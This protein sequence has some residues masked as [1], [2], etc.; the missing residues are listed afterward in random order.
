MSFNWKWII[1][2]SSLIIQFIA[3]GIVSSFGVLLL[4]II[5]VFHTNAEVASWIGSIQIFVVHFTGII[6][7]PLLKIFGARNVVIAGSILCAGGCLASAFAPNV[8]V[9][10]FTYGTLTGI[11]SGFMNVTTIVVIQFWFAESQRALATGIVTSGVGLGTAVFNPLLEYLTKTVHFHWTQR[12]MC[13]IFI[14]GVPCGMLF[15]PFHDEQD[16]FNVQQHTTNEE[17][18]ESKANINTINEKGIVKKCDRLTTEV[19]D[20]SLFERPAFILYCFASGMHAFGLYVPTTYIPLLVK[21]IGIPPKYSTYLLSIFGISNISS[22]FICGCFGNIGG[23]TRFYLMLT[24]YIG[25]GFLNVLISLHNS[26]P[27]LVIYSVCFSALTGCI[28]TLYAVVLV[29]LFGIENVEKSVGLCLFLTS[30]FY[31]L[32]VPMS[33]FIIDR[34]GSEVLPFTI[35]G[36]ISLLGAF[37]FM[38]IKCFHK[39]NDY[40]QFRD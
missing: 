27:V 12:V 30:F 40:E 7:G 19:A 13:L 22:R 38:L 32:G 6:G 14:I 29:D 9:L 35:I 37:T 11:G 17:E 34:T 28:N 5:E 4:N 2:F 33:G 25:I 36:I 31:L 20:C 10:Y 26:Y 8:Y 39:E 21:S 15:K 18:N 24:S 3:F 23:S 1:V 16:A